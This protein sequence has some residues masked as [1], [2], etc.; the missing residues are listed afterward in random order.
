MK[1]YKATA[2]YMR[3]GKVNLMVT[4]D[5]NALSQ[6]QALCVASNQ[7]KDASITVVEC[8]EINHEHRT[9]VHDSNYQRAS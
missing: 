4:F 1:K 9:K 3:N 2:T 7:W 5:L 6:E 8:G